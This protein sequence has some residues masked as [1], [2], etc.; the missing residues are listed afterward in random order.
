[1]AINETE[2]GGPEDRNN[3]VFSFENV[4]VRVHKD[5]QFMTRNVQF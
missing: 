2:K 4:R 3:F 1:M 5:K